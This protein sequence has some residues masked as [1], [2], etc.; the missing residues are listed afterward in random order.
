M[1][2]IQAFEL[3]KTV[4]TWV[5]T[6]NVAKWVISVS[7]SAVRKAFAVTRSVQS[8]HVAS[9]DS[10]GVS[11]DDLHTTEVRYPIDDS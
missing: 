2:I 6:R 5:T 9:C 11:Y 8:D 7:Q 3:S 10:F 4:A 1:Y